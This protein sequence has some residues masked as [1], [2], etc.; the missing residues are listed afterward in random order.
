MAVIV[1]VLGGLAVIGVT[2]LVLRQ[3]GRAS[4]IATGLAGAAG[5]AAY[6]AI[7]SPA[8]PDLPFSERAA[9]L[10]SR[11][12]R[13]LSPA[14]TLARLELL[15]RE[16][17][18]DPQPHFF[19][20]E[21]MKAQGRD[22]DAVRAYQSALRR[23]SRFAPA[24]EGLADALVR[25]EGGRVGA[26]AQRVY[27][28]LYAE[29]PARLRAGFLAGLGLLQAGDPDAADAAWASMRAN[30]EAGDPR[31]AMLDAWIDAAKTETAAP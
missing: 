22:D 15:V 27:A 7:G 25:L 30:L 17:P 13:D 12:A 29:D 1:F 16:R 4:A 14:E 9:E 20:G 28:Q 21:V 31:Q 8:A 19:I 5:L 3:S 26:D 6:A 2:A 24:L 10:A 18:D 23:D 11:D